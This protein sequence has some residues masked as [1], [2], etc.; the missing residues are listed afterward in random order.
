[1]MIVIVP[2][3]PCERGSRTELLVVGTSPYDDMMS[4]LKRGCP[5]ARTAIILKW[6]ST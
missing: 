5:E 6:D 1:M 2:I 4:L 3:N